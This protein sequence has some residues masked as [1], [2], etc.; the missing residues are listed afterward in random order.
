MKGGSFY[1]GN[2][3]GQLKKNRWENFCLAYCYGLS[4]EEAAIKAGYPPRVAGSIGLKLLKNNKIKVRIKEFQETAENGAT[5]SVQERKERLSEIARANLVDFVAEDGQTIKANK[6]IPNYGALSQFTVR[7]TYNK[8]GEP[9]VTREIR[10]QS[11]IRAI[12]ELNK[13][14]RLDTNHKSEKTLSEDNTTNIIFIMPDGSRKTP[15]ELINRH[16]V[17]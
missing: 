13:M 15:R 5:M 14:E 16:E 11:Q 12:A 4:A 8:A 1:L 3:M 2:I 7:T 17:N 10:M 6:N 9:I